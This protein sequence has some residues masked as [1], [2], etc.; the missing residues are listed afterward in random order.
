MKATVRKTVQRQKATNS[1]A[2]LAH[3]GYP[4]RCDDGVD[5]W[6]VMLQLQVD[7]VEGA[8]EVP[9][10]VMSLVMIVM[11]WLRLSQICEE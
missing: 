10:I 3:C 1:L 6:V 4:L 2:S 9:G 7:A 8:V 11:C 5:S